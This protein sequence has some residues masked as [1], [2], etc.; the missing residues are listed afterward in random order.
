MGGSF[1]PIRGPAF[2]FDSFGQ[3]PPRQIEAIIELNSREGWKYNDRKIQNDFS[4][5]CGLY[6][7]LF[8]KFLPDYNKFI[9]K[10]INC[11]IRNEQRL[12]KLA[13]SKK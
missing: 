12:L 9:A 1:F 4:I 10:F 5:S 3:P 6:C 13:R 11:S 7:I 8:V 2:F